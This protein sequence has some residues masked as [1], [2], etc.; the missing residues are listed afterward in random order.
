[1]KLTTFLSLALLP[2]Y[3]APAQIIDH[4]QHLYSPKAGA[5]SSPGSKGIRVTDLIAGLD[6][7]GIQRALVLSVAYSFANPNKPKDPDEYI[8]VQAE[9]DWTSAQVAKYPD[10]LIGFCGVNPL[11]P[12]ALDEIARCAKDPHLRTGLKLHFGN[13]DVDVT[14]AEQL[15]QLRRVFRAANGNHMA[16]VVH[17]R[18]SVDRNRPYGAAQARIMLEQLLPE[19]PDV[20]IQIAHLAGAGGYD[21]PTDQSLQVFIDALAGNDPRVKRLYFDVCGVS[22]LGDWNDA[23]AALVAKR[24]HQ[25][26][27]TRLLY[28][29]DAPVPGNMPA[30]AL[31]RWHQLPLTKDEFHAVESNIAPYLRPW[32]QADS[33]PWIQSGGLK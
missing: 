6:A 26:G 19:V 31:A 20:T 9:N 28:G 11:R 23:K 17:M 7:A 29:S 5:R 16:L 21:D 25:I 15:A 24:I 3:P 14:N 1:M 2:A 32:L 18:P 30:E 33:R 4:H 8:D 22:G 27:V 12:Y 10:R 13:S